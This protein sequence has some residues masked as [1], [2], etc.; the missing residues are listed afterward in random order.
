MT[1]NFLPQSDCPLYTSPRLEIF[2]DVSRSFYFLISLLKGATSKSEFYRSCKQNS[3]HFFKHP[4]TFDVSNSLFLQIYY[5]LKIDFS[6]MMIFFSII[7]EDVSIKMI[8]LLIRVNLSYLKRRVM[9]TLSKG[10]T[11]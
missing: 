1:C 2:I 11:R 4:S 5:S 6:K 8:S 10:F 3:S 7:A 9:L